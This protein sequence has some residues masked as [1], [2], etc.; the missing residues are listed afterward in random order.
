[1]VLPMRADQHGCVPVP[2]WRVSLAGRGALAGSA[3]R[4]REQGHRDSRIL[5]ERGKGIGRGGGAGLFQHL[6]IALSP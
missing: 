6:H 2:A 3:R 4:G 5:A 1:M